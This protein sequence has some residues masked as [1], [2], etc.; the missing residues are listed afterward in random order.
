MIPI[1]YGNVM[2]LYAF[3]D[4]IKIIKIHACRSGG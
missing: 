4:P 2:K 3:I 1:F